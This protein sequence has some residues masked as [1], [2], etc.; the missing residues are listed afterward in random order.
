[1]TFQKTQ[2]DR[3]DARLAAFLHEQ[4]PPEH[5]RAQLDYGYAIS[6]Q[7]VELQEIR[8]RWNDPTQKITRSFAKA[9]FVKTREVWR[10]YWMRADL[11][12]HPYNP[13]PIVATLEEFLALVTRDEHACF[14]G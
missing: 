14:Y 3:I 7:S 5:I 12:W 8:P 6:G 11:K 1:M 9:T 13:A 2:F 10:V 4:R